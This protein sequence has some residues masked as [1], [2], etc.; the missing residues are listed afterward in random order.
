MDNTA[1]K[2]ALASANFTVDDNGELHITK[3]Q[4][5]QLGVNAGDDVA[6]TPS[7]ALAANAKETS[8]RKPTSSFLN[9]VDELR[10]NNILEPVPADHDFD[11][12]IRAALA[13]K[14]ALAGKSDR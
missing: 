14:H 8:P 2:P 6:V 9:Y 10:R 7:E 4:L 11:Q 13:E 1:A 5:Q 12:D 3:D